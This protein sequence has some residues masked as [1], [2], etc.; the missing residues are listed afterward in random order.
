MGKLGEEASALIFKILKRGVHEASGEADLALRYDHTVPLAR[1]VGTYGSRLPSPYKR[2]AIGNVWRADRAAKGRFREFTQC[3]IDTVGSSSPPAD[4][5]IVWAVNEG[6]D[7]LGVEEFRFLVNSRHALHGLLE[8][9]GIPP[10]LGT[11]MLGSLDKLDKTPP[12]AVTAEL[13]ERGL[14][15]ETAEGLVADVNAS[16]RSRQPRTRSRTVVTLH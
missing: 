9:Y 16:S 6:L 8:A 2:Y 12:D 13:V 11:T 3:D 4:A 14:T 10:E 7:A 5:E 15:T 1:V